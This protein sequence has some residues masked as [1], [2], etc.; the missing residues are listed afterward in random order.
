MKKI[1]L[2]AFLAIISTAPAYAEDGRG[3]GGHYGGDRGGGRHYG[4]DRGDGGGGGYYRDHRDGGDGGHY[5]DRR[6]G[7]DGGDG[8]GNWIFPALIGGA[9]GYGLANQTY[10]QPAPPPPVYQQ[11]PPVFAPSSAQ[12]WYF[13]PAFNAYYPYV[14]SC[15][16]QWQPVL[17]MP[18]R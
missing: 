3:D 13:C 16:T 7:G 2:V 12:Y 17:A 10:T 4:G 5:E 11:S 6:D 9:I 18:P 8:E 14:S 15:P 1:L